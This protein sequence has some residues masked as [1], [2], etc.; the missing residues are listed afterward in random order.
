MS[1]PSTAPNNF[2]LLRV[3]AAYQVLAMH[4]SEWLKVEIFDII[5]LFPGVPVF[6]VISGFL[7]TNSWITRQQTIKEYAR[8]RILRVYPGMIVNLIA[9]FV[10]MLA[11][12]AI[13]AE[14]LTNGKL[15][16]YFTAIALTG[17]TKLGGAL[18][19]SKFF[20]FGADTLPFFPG[21]AL[22]T[23][24]VEIGFY[25]ALPWLLTLSKR[26]LSAVFF[27]SLGLC[28]AQM[29]INS[30]WLDTTVPAYLWIFMIGVVAR[31]TWK[32][33]AVLLRN[34]FP[35]WLTAHL[36]LWVVPDY[37]NTSPLIFLS[38]LTLS[39]C[40]LSFAHTFVQLSAVLRRQD[41]SYG[42]YLYHMPIILIL[43][44]ADFTNSMQS[45]WLAIGATTIAASI[46]WILVERPCIK[47]KNRPTRS[48]RDVPSPAT[49]L[50][51]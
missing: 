28:T 47:L 50:H 22:W 18:A 4:A 8:N 16:V 7:L 44:H 19:G 11:T 43:M 13:A 17:W 31:L 38:V 37:R 6:F 23:V 39:G 35:I 36:L 25:I 40:I 14:A 33:T 5:S 3:M 42:V 24:G 20:N 12:G 26:Q 2:D 49:L 9:I 32:E 45:L 29:W 10:L 1:E 41:I 15:Y 51:R 30:S 48:T 34:T 27:L 21:G 46:S